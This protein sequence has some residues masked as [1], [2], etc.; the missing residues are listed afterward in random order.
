MGINNVRVNVGP[1]NSNT[2]HRINSNP[3]IRRGSLE[4][5][6]VINVQ[7]LN[8]QPESNSSDNSS[9]CGFRARIRRF[10]SNMRSCFSC[11][12]RSDPSARS[13]SPDPAVSGR[14]NHAFDG[15]GGL[16]S[17]RAHQPQPSSSG[18][19][20]SVK[21]S[22]A[23]AQPVQN[24]PAASAPNLFTPPQ[25]LTP[26][27]VIINSTELAF[28]RA[29]STA[30][31]RMAQ[32]ESNKIRRHFEDRNAARERTVT[33]AARVLEYSKSASAR[34]I[35]L[36]PVGSY[37]L[38]KVEIKA[39]GKVGLSHSMKGRVMLKKARLVLEPIPGEDGRWRLME[40]NG[41][42]YPA[43]S[44]LEPVIN[45]AKLDLMEGRHSLIVNG[46]SFVFEMGS[47]GTGTV[48]CAG[49]RNSRGGAQNK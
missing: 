26:N 4:S 47:D 21:G 48:S 16:N 22:A 33:T 23:D 28:A 24:P 31:A 5:I 18:K 39:N 45:K 13:N 42:R 37:G 41:K 25:P 8:I 15:D 30:S 38:I 9:P 35:S 40:T 19:T 17:A 11:Y 27:V 1:N 49:M 36:L 3:C 2:T 44:A 46:H 34:L 12:K 10:F 14:I 7:D 20:Q 32:A 29:A 43:I 6:R